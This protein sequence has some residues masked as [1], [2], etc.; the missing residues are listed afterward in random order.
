[1]EPSGR[2]PAPGPLPGVPGTPHHPTS[3][4]TG[5]LL[6]TV[7]GRWMLGGCEEHPPKISSDG[8]PGSPN[9]PPMIGGIETLTQKSTHLTSI[10]GFPLSLS[11]YIYIYIHICSS[12]RVQSLYSTF[13][14][15]SHRRSLPWTCLAQAPTQDTCWPG[16]WSSRVVIPIT[17]IGDNIK[18]LMNINKPGSRG[19]SKSR[20]VENHRIFWDVTFMYLF[21][22][23]IVIDYTHQVF[24]SPSTTARSTNNPSWGHQSR[25]SN[26][27]HVWPK[28]FFP[29][30]YP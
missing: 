7:E 29:L 11:L 17:D 19:S 26:D 8:G 28:Y 25:Y 1:M 23:G 24:A 21:I 14:A 5:R 4:A 16:R 13:I 15:G 22:L 30:Q 2:L 9:T 3:S 12:S 18:S 27:R 6:R 20:S 10:F